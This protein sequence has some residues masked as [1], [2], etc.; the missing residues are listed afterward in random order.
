MWGKVEKKQGP[1]YRQI[2]EQIMRK[3]KVEELI[4]EINLNRNEN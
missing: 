3:S 4:L 2:M 1:I